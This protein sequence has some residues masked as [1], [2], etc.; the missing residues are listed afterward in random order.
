M[1]SVRLWK[2]TR[3]FR[4]STV[5]DSIS[6]GRLWL[7]VRKEELVRSVCW[8]Q[9]VATVLQAD[10]NAVAYSAGDGHSLQP[11]QQPQGATTAAAGETAGNP[12]PFVY[13][14]GYRLSGA[15][16]D[17][18][19]I[20]PVGGAG[21]GGAPTANANATLPPNTTDDIERQKRLEAIEKR[22]VS[23]RPSL[24]CILGLE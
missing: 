17:P 24:P 13:S 16:G 12:S 19:K 1:L 15:G 8:C 6:N 11:K 23:A 4:P 3:S 10:Y 9:P 22:A 2:T 7:K 5:I 21:G 20:T 14:P 18:E